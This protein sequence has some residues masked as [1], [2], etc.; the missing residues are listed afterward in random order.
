MFVQKLKEHQFIS[1]HD[2][3]C[4]PQPFAASFVWKKS[5]LFSFVETNST[6]LTAQYVSHIWRSFSTNAFVGSIDFLL[7]FIGK[8][9]FEICAIF[10]WTENFAGVL[11]A[12]LFENQGFLEGKCHFVAVLRPTVF[13][14][15]SRYRLADVIC[16]VCSIQSFADISQFYFTIFQ[17]HDFPQF[18]DRKILCKIWNPN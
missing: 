16:I 18:F 13:F 3:V 14:L 15:V 17:I 12:K 5:F 4:F 10:W 11:L 1:M 7:S 8:V 2:V 9:L 6:L